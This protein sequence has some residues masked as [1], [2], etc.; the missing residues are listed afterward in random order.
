MFSKFIECNI[1]DSNNMMSLLISFLCYI[2]DY[3]E[4]RT[5]KVQLQLEDTSFHALHLKLPS[6][7]PNII[8]LF[9]IILLI[10]T[11]KQAVTLIN[12]G[13]STLPHCSR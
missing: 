13:S 8:I 10:L 5:M 7:V 3:L 6:I 12:H 2:T 11:K 1:L 4:N 9:I